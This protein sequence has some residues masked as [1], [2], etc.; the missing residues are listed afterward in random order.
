ML[1]FEKLIRSALADGA[2]RTARNLKGLIEAE[3]AVAPGVDAV[4]R[5]P[6]LSPIHRSA[7]TCIEMHAVC[8]HF[9][10]CLFIHP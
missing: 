2:A 1:P 8:P 3:W 9:P 6:G 10:N 4:C 7:V 5:Q